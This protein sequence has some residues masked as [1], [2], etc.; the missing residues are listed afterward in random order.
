MLLGRAKKVQISRGTRSPDMASTLSSEVWE[1]REGLNVPPVPWIR[2][3]PL[4]TVEDPRKAERDRKY[5]ENEALIRELR[6]Q[7]KVLRMKA[8]R[9]VAREKEGLPSAGMTR[10]Q[11]IKHE[12]EVA[13]NNM[14]KVVDFHVQK[15]E[16]MKERTK[17]RRSDPL[18]A[19]QNE[20]IEALRRRIEHENAQ[21]ELERTQRA[22]AAK[23]KQE[24]EVRRQ[25]EKHDEIIAKREESARAKKEEEEK[26]RREMEEKK[27]ATEE[28]LERLERE[29]VEERE[30]RDKLER[31]ATEERERREKLER[32]AMEE[33]ERREKLELELRRVRENPPAAPPPPRAPVQAA[34]HIPVTDD[35]FDEDPPVHVSVPRVMEEEPMAA[36]HVWRPKS[37]PK[38][39][40]D[41]GRPKSPRVDSRSD[42]P[43]KDPSAEFS[44]S[45]DFLDES[46][47]ERER[48]KWNAELERRRRELED[49]LRAAEKAKIAS[50]VDARVEAR[51]RQM[52]ETAIQADDARHEDDDFESPASP[53]PSTAVPDKLVAS[54]PR[55][56]GADVVGGS[57]AGYVIARGDRLRV[58]DRLL[59]RVYH[60]RFDGE[61]YDANRHDRHGSEDVISRV[62]V[63]AETDEGAP[64]GEIAMA[65]ACDAVTALIRSIPRGDG[66]P[67]PAAFLDDSSDGA[68]MAQEGFPRHNDELSEPDALFAAQEL[69]DGQTEDGYNAWTALLAH[70]YQ[71]A[72][73]G[74]VD[75]RASAEAMAEMLV[76]PDRAGA[77]RATRTKKTARLAQLIRALFA[78][79][80]P[81]APPPPGHAPSW[82]RNATPRSVTRSTER[83]ARESAKSEREPASRQ[84]SGTGLFGTVAT[85][86]IKPVGARRPGTDTASSSNVPPSTYASQFADGLDDSDELEAAMMSTTTR[87]PPPRNTYRAPPP[88]PVEVPISPKAGNTPSPAAKT[89]TPSPGRPPRSPKAQ[90][91]QAAA[92]EGG[93]RRTKT[94]TGPTGAAAKVGSIVNRA[95]GVDDGDDSL[96]ASGLLDQMEPEKSLN[97]SDSFD[98]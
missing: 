65:I 98:F 70:F 23:K 30:R 1:L 20:K 58:L 25:R 6:Q 48:E 56:A 15:L 44:D 59:E 84:Q 35:S 41:A 40:D 89:Q 37:P 66:E 32:E 74:A 39:P 93:E 72:E 4:P 90:T 91:R 94:R 22:D 10:E 76:P 11:L 24:E 92:R 17:Q 50:E 79:Y 95:F 77:S 34:T 57:G 60:L 71:M 43:P 8:E 14:A 2:D 42:V 81:F 28:R 3:K 38:S 96:N 75:P 82:R 52:N 46:N 80:D 19:G 83:R 27:S 12:A 97:A 33:R 67:V 31:E 18:F 47:E 49:E 7:R 5:M 53:S 13:M 55:S 63:A 9:R 73:A 26:I 16:Q 86:F 85:S 69:R 21:Y 36:G 51:V 64:L 45:A 61:F 87:V 62:F 29:A 78:C 88:P 54:S 68:F